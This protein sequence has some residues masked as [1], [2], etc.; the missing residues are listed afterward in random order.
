[1]APAKRKATCQELIAQAEALGIKRTPA[2]HPIFSEG[3]SISFRSRPQQTP[4]FTQLR[5]RNED[6][7]EFEDRDS[8]KFCGSTTGCEHHLLGVDMTFFTIDGGAL[9]DKATAIWSE[10]YAQ[11]KEE[12]GDEFDEFDS[13]CNL[14]QLVSEVADDSASYDFDGPPGQSSRYTNYWCSSAERVTAAVATFNA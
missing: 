9:Y 7:R 14:L 6:G 3:P 12:D 1:M 10:A 13:F 2:D 5:P 8:C 11:G 4:V